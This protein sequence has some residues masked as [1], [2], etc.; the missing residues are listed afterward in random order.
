MFSPV[1]GYCLENVFSMYRLWGGKAIYHF[2]EEKE[3]VRI[4]NL[5]KL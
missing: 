5:I 1:Y 2:Q 3:L 4:K